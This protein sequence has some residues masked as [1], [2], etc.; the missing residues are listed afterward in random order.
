MKIRERTWEE[1]GY[2]LAKGCKTEILQ[3]FITDSRL[4]NNLTRNKAEDEDETKDM[5]DSC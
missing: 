4:L 5:K 2:Q 3:S 1:I